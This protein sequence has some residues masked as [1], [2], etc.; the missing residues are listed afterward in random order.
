VYV[1]GKYRNNKSI[2]P[3]DA[4]QLKGLCGVLADT[5]K[6]FSKTELTNILNQSHI[7][8]ADD[9]HS[10]DGYTYTS[11]LNKRDWLFNCF[12]EEI[13]KTQTDQK[14]FDFIENALNPILYTDMKRR[15]FYNTL[16]SFTHKYLGECHKMPIIQGE[17][18]S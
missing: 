6:G 18:G 16:I 11:G 9:G 14:I 12:V 10:S 2:K 7:P 3:L 15:D 4:Q 5:D 17:T 1:R 13:K 8:L